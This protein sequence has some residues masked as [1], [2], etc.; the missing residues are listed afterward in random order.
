MIAHLPELEAALAR[1]RLG[2]LE[3][4]ECVYRALT[5]RH[6]ALAEPW[7]LLGVVHLQRSKPNE[8]EPY[9]RQ[10]LVCDAG[11]VKGRT[12]LGVALYL[13]QRF[14]EAEQELRLALERQPDH[15]DALYNL[16]LVLIARQKF[17]A[18]LA[19]FEALLK[20]QPQ[21]VKALINAG[22]LLQRK[23]VFEKAKRYLQSAV[24]LAPDDPAAHINLAFVL[25]QMNAVS[26][27]RTAIDVA[28]LKAPLDARANLLAATLDVREKN[29]QSAVTR[30]QGVLRRAL[31]PDLQAHAHRVMGDACEAL[32]QADEAF[33]HYAHANGI[34]VRAAHAQG[35]EPARF[36]ERIARAHRR[37]DLATGRDARHPSE[38]QSGSAPVFF[39]GFPRSGTT[40]FEQMLSMHPELVTTNENSP[41]VKMLRGQDLDALARCADVEHLN[42]LRTQ[43][44]HEAEIIV[45]NA[46]NG[47]ILIDTAPLNIRLLDVA[48]H[49]FPGA[50]VIVMLRDPR[51]VCLSCFM[52]A[53]ALNEEL[54]NFLTL[55]TTATVYDKLMGLWLRQKNELAMTYIEMR[56]EDII[57]DMQGSVRRALAFLNV[58][59][60]DDIN[61]YREQAAKGHIVTPSYRQVG[62]ELHTRARGRWRRYA[63]QLSPIM[64]TLAPYVKALGYEP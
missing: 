10:A 9:F 3:E 52:Q 33:A 29:P 39:V 22:E 13:L 8:A 56:Y 31:E 45:G 18:A 48:L 24:A 49:L 42:A 63:H 16:G 11:H 59:W 26:E 36:V 57:V 53:F 37:L 38:K 17:D 4:A 12:N 61:A 62:E 55:E 23:H 44:W 15:V 1:H 27:A 2:F 32:N 35:L 50:K 20:I 5:D 28:L 58:P 43:F 40:L 6:P 47:R 25:E 51:D 46:L 54:G 14:E 19:A 60:T 30:L 41:L 34:Q 64:A 21:H 7:H